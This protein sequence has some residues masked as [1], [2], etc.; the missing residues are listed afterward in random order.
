MTAYIANHQK[1]NRIFNKRV[2]ELEHAVKNK[3]NYDKIIKAA[4]RV[5]EAK[6]NVYKSRFSEKS[7]L[8]AS[9]WTPDVVALKWQAYT[10]DE[11][12]QVCKI[13]IPE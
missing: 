4:E 11:I 13:K 9:S 5:R 6:M 8:P 1:K 12:L 3:F 2:H 7:V 10:V